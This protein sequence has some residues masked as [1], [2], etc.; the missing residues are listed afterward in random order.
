MA[1]VVVVV[2][3]LIQVVHHQAGR[4]SIVTASIRFLFC[5]SLSSNYGV[6]CCGG[7]V[8]VVVVVVL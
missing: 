6:G 3:G 7:G 2:L 8:L 5:S 4:S 1:V